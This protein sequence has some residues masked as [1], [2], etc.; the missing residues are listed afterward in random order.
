MVPFQLLDMH[1]EVDD[2]DSIKDTALNIYFA[3]AEF[4]RIVHT[5]LLI[6]H[7]SFRK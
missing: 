2:L 1:V 6:T 5:I 7:F 4:A 3:S